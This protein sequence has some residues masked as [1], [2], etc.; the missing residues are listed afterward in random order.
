VWPRG[1]KG[2]LLILLIVLAVAL[3]AAQTRALNRGRPSPLEAPAILLLKPFQN[4]VTAVSRAWDSAIGGTDSRLSLAAEN[5][6]LREQVSLLTVK[7]AHLS[8]IAAENA[9]LR[10]M[11]SMKQH[12]PSG[13]RWIV[14]DVLE[15]HP[16]HWFDMLTLDCGRSAG[17]RQHSIVL[18]TRG[19]VGKVVVVRSD[20]CDAL[21]ITDPASDT[22]AFVPRTRDVGYVEGTGHQEMTLHFF[23]RDHGVRV[24]DSVVSSPF[25]ATY[26]SGISIGKVT[27]ITKDAGASVSQASIQP[28][29]QFNDL[30]EAIVIP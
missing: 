4:C 9:R 28:S 19:L 23:D 11:L 15:R 5:R 1:R 14:A 7:N 18:T 17:V 30:G 24:G 25:S 13:A 21:L 16:S 26:P 8:H 20:T 6:Q 10:A 3:T 22:G 2:W 27:A 29:V 12:D